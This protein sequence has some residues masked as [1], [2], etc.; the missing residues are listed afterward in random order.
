MTGKAHGPSSPCALTSALRCCCSLGTAWLYFGVLASVVLMKGGSCSTLLYLQ[1]SCEDFLLSPIKGAKN[2]SGNG[3]SPG[4]HIQRFHQIIR[5]KL[6]NSMGSRCS[7]QDKAMNDW[8]H[9]RDRENL[10]QERPQPGAEATSHVRACYC[11]MMSGSQEW[12]PRWKSCPAFRKL[13]GTLQK[14]RPGCLR[15]VQKKP[16]ERWSRSYMLVFLTTCDSS[17]IDPNKNGFLMLHSQSY[18]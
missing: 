4:S 3:S 5:R 13:W 7:E 11:K 14:I 12:L 2:V 17:L 16:K 15:K 9:L 18:G 1:G 6:R 10:H 8:C